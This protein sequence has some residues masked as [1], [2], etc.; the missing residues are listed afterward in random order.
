MIHTISVKCS[1]HDSDI[2]LDSLIAFE[3]SLISVRIID[4][5]KRI[6][7]WDITN[8]YFT[9]QNGNEIVSK[10]CVK[11]NGVWV[12]TTDSVAEPM[13]SWYRISAKGIDENG[14]T[15]EAYNLG[16]GDITILDTDGTIHIGDTEYYVH[17]LDT[18]PEVPKKGDMLYFQDTRTWNLYDG[19]QWVEI[20]SKIEVATKDKIGGIRATEGFIELNEDGDIVSLQ[21]SHAQSSYEA[22]VADEAKYARKVDDETE[23]LSEYAKKSELKKPVFSCTFVNNQTN[24]INQ[25]V[26]LY[27]FLRVGE[28]TIQQQIKYISVSVKAKSQQKFY[29]EMTDDTEGVSLALGDVYM[30]YTDTTGK[31]KSVYKV[32][33]IDSNTYADVD[34]TKDIVATSINGAIDV[35]V[36]KITAGNN[37]TISPASGTGAVTVNAV[38]PSLPIATNLVLGGIKAT[39][40]YIEIG[41]DG[42]ITRLDAD[43]ARSADEC[44]TANNASHADWADNASNAEIAT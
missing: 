43:Y 6:G 41:S 42:N 10:E 30:T 16:Q 36:S 35:G 18:L 5:P 25:K 33:A 20:S 7:T 26:T 21:A 39:P 15:V 37:I 44:Y 38:V 40:D 32:R 9:F 27:K 34:W 3:G 12:A 29:T 22:Q 4:V 2:K 17:L 13:T 23:G 1:S 19:T 14:E 11:T 28:M 24:D 31:Q 8:V